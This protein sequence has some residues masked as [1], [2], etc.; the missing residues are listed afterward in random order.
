MSYF[1]K[2]SLQLR[3]YPLKIANRSLGC[4]ELKSSFRSPCELNNLFHFKYILQKKICSF[5]DF[6][7][8]CN[9]CILTY[10][11]KTYHYFFTRTA[12]E[13]M[14]VSNYNWRK[15]RMSSHQQFMTT[16]NSVTVYVTVQLILATL[17]F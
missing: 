9:N 5:S 15:L 11:D 6:R 10:Y 8:T 12:A 16:L 13:H 3:S 7:F 17:A 4:C 2:D 1:S 14:G